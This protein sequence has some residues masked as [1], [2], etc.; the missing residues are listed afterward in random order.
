MAG[1]EISMLCDGKLLQTVRNSTHTHG[2]VGVG[3]DWSG[4]VF[5][6][7]SV[8]P[9]GPAKNSVE[10]NNRTIFEKPLQFAR[11][12]EF[13]AKVEAGRPGTVRV[14]FTPGQADAA[15]RLKPAEDVWDLDQ[16]AAVLVD[17]RNHGTKPAALI[18]RL[19][20]R[21]WTSSLVVV[22]PRAT[23]TLWLYVKREKLP[24]NCIDRFPGMFGVPGGALWCWDVP[25]PKG[26]KELTFVPAGDLPAEDI[27]IGNL[28]A[29][30]WN[31]PIGKAAGPL[32]DSI[33][34]FVDQYGQYLHR[35]WPGKIQTDSDLI[36]ARKAEDAE[37]KQH[38][39]PTDWDAYG[40]WAKGPRLKATGHFR[41]E[42][43][44]GKWWLVDPD[45]RLFWSHGITCVGGNRTTSVRNRVRFFASLPPEAIRTGAWDGLDVIQK[46][47]GGNQAA[48][49]DLAHVRL[50]SWG[51]NTL[52]N[53]SDEVLCLSRP[54]RTPY[55]LTV[56]Y[57]GPKLKNGFPDVANPG[58]RAALANA[59]AGFARKGAEK[60]PYCIGAFIDNELPSWTENEKVAETYFST[61]REEMRKALPNL[62]YL[63]CRFDFH[64][65]PAEGPKTP[66]LMAAK[67]C[68]V[69]SFN[70][71]RFTADELRL[72]D[73]AEDKPIIIGEFHF[74]ALD[75]GPLHTGLGSVSSQSQRGEAYRMFL[76][77]GLR[78]PAIVGA[79]WF[80]YCDEPTSGRFDGENYQIGFVDVC[81]GPYAETIAASRDMGQSLYSLRAARKGRP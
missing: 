31:A 73:G 44:D 32:D 25:D 77:T 7:F 14:R 74:G 70:R 15:V 22:P 56:H 36:A 76:R 40:G 33:F 21:T 38:P 51:L 34:P 1:D 55:V 65:F 64:Y 12:E 81:D 62:L 10:T 53:W 16:A 42:K 8:Q 28:R 35:D 78:N 30:P 37:L 48:Y 47:Y 29:R 79:H 54:H 27:E 57:G 72:P 49:Y 17:I 19:D 39:G 46:K 50:R 26:I 11:H 3:C 58:F 80:Q 9:R 5:A 45:G 23:E 59:L 13:G 60:D 41:T 6:N 61:C 18:G 67:Y 43:L 69:V 2:L 20:K 52:G 66:V 24:K 63:G 71:Y 75:R 68:D 4:A